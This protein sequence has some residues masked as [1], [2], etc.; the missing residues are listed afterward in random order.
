MAEAFL[1]AA[2]TTPWSRQ[3]IDED[4]GTVVQVHAQARCAADGSVN[5]KRSR[6]QP[7]HHPHA[8][9]TP[10]LT[11]E[12]HLAL[13][14]LMLARGTTP[15]TPS[16]QEH[17]CSVCGRTFPSHQALGGHKSSHRHRASRTPAATTSPP[18]D[19]PASSASPAASPSTSG[20]ASTGRVHKC[21]VCRKTFPTGQ[22]LGGHK[23]CHYEGSAGAATTAL[24]NSRGFDLNVPALPDLMVDADWC[25]LL[26]AAE[27]EEGEEVLSPLAFKKPGLMI[28]A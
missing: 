2:A 22:A 4:D 27:A 19:D 3:Q 12:E 20:A 1:E 24:L 8:A 7:R 17:R 25:M 13:C 10:T 6:R 9:L 21:S 26:P 16:P 11:E 5:C 28:M 18:A 23:R 15:P 14:L